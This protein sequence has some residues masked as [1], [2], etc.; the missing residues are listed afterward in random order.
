MF[1]SLDVVTSRTRL[2]LPHAL[3]LDYCTGSI[4]TTI[5]LAEGVEY[6]V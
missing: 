4:E 3:D 6:I 1:E 2:R 5:R